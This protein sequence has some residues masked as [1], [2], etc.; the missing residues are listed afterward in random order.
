[1]RRAIGLTFLGAGMLAFVLASVLIFVLVQT[2]FPAL[3]GWAIEQQRAFQNELALA[4][5]AIRAG[6]TGAWLTLMAAA[7]GYGFVH[8]VGPGHGKYLI[9][10]VGLGH[11]ISAAKLLGIAAISSLAQALWAIALVYGGLHLLEVSARRLTAITDLYLA[12]ASHIAIGAVGVWLIWRGIAMLLARRAGGGG[13]A[14]NGPEPGSR[15]D[16]ACGCHAA[17][18]PRVEDVARLTSMREAVVLILSIAV[19]PCTGAVFL[20]VIAWQLD[21]P[22]AGAAAVVTM[23]LGT[24]LLTGSV[25]V[26]SVAAR[27]LALASTDRMGI[28]A[29]VAPGFQIAAGGLIV[30][31]STMLFNFSAL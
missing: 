7:G 5:Q 4:V 15:H 9:G 17:H 8:A 3:A 27:G 31:F 18:G 25:A 11:S 20:L 23:G 21:I 26:F 16:H 10:G 24:A 28:A 29:V 12:P 19:R 30:W 6:D 2:W 14:G 1:M 22:L 13:G